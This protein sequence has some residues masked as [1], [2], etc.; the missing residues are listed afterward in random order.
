MTVTREELAEAITS[1]LL[2]VQDKPEECTPS[3]VAVMID[4]LRC[5]LVFLANDEFDF[6][7]VE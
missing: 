2:V 4:L 6:I 7:E 1:T 3:D 5:S